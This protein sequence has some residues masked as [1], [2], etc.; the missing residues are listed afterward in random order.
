MKTL[1]TG[2][3][4]VVLNALGGCTTLRQGDPAS[5]DAATD[6]APL[7]VYV[8]PPEASLD[9]APDLTRDVPQEISTDTG[10][11]LDVGDRG[12][13]TAPRPIAPLTSTWVTT[14][15]VR[16]RW[17]PEPGK[18][19]LI[20][21]CDDARCALN[22]RMI[23]GG[24]DG[25]ETVSATLTPGNHWWRLYGVVNG[26]RGL[27]PSPAWHFV[28]E[29]RGDAPS[30]SLGPMID[31]NGDGRRD[32]VVGAPGDAAGD[33]TVHI[34]RD[35]TELVE[36]MQRRLSGVY[37]SAGVALCAAG[38]MNG[39]GLGDLAFS[40]RVSL[41]GDGEV[42]VVPGWRDGVPMPRPVVR[43][44]LGDLAFGA[45][46]AGVG[47]LDGDGYADLVVGQPPVDPSGRGRLLVYAGGPTGYR[48][49]PG[50]RAGVIRAWEVAGTVTNA[51]F[52]AALAATGD[53]NGDGFDD[54]AVS[55]VGWSNDASAYA[56]DV[57]VYLG[58][59]GAWHQQ[60]PLRLV[61]PMGPGNYYGFALAG[62]GD[63]N[64]DGY[65]D[66]A[67]GAPGPGPGM[68]ESRVYVHYGGSTGPR[69]SADVVLMAPE[70]P[71]QFGVAVA[72]VG[73]I[74]QDG[75]ADV[76]VASPG[77]GGFGRVYVH[78][79]S[80]TGLRTTASY[81][82]DAPG[83]TGPF[84]RA[85]GSRGD[86]DGDGIPDLLTG[87]PAWNMNSGRAFVFR[88]TSRGPEAMSWRTLEGTSSG[89]RFGESL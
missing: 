26:V 2:W 51:R 52:A 28:V 78:K 46:L 81:T 88:G 23:D 25:E 35:P 32:V 36:G 72:G 17:Q 43:T 1:L 49:W 48:N 83:R 59:A 55:T 68:G 63:V 5:L 62:V 12:R 79:G 40:A 41:Y 27:Y 65:P 47:D 20:E 76:A 24:D 38:D 19:A 50:G 82:L 11:P 7:D 42:L 34:W 57:R 4:L 56:G 39:D 21:L 45:S 86:I 30:R 64:A 6:R 53:M 74:D 84:A 75:F 37:P 29:G 58:G 66:L 13:I 85:L 77:A 15:R 73:D 33:G 44:N 16:F 70:V 18:R 80:V 61:S 8:P 10:E 89:A 54:F 3:S 14:G 69:A 9:V 31:T 67:I 87:D 22:P 60:T 71:G